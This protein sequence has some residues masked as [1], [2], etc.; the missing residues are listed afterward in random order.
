MG[1]Q[2]ESRETSDAGSHALWQTQAPD[3]AK[4]AGIFRQ[5]LSHIKT[6]SLSPFSLLHQRNP[7]PNVTLFFSRPLHAH[8]DKTEMDRYLKQGSEHGQ[9]IFVPDR[10]S[11]V[12]VFGVD[13]DVVHLLSKK[14]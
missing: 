5:I 9:P 10:F 1:P 13:V 8:I 11:D 6:K 7:D 2:S 4:T 12:A 14:K 3:A